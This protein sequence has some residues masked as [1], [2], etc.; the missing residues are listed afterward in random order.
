[1]N[2]FGPRAR[3]F[4][5]IAAYILCNLYRSDKISY[6]YPLLHMRKLRIRK[7]SWPV[8]QL[9][10]TIYKFF[11]GLIHFFVSQFFIPSFSFLSFPLLLAKYVF[12]IFL[13]KFY[14]CFKQPL[15]NGPFFAGYINFI[16]VSFSNPNPI[17][18]RD[19]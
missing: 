18:D 17:T 8:I 16:L 9:I 11:T 7:R 13:R 2:L 15:L 3:A 14:K 10:M 4:N 5:R 19:F 6:H 12:F 1:M